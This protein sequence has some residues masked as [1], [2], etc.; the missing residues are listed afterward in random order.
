MSSFQGSRVVADHVSVAKS[1]FL[2]V[3]DFT[4]PCSANKNS[5]L[6][7]SAITVEPR[8]EHKQE[9]DIKEFES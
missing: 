1:F 4:E 6:E 8:Y 9:T 3:N 2:S 7:S 5:K